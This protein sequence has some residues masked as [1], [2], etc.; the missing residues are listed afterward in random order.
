M[1]GR[2]HEEIWSRV[3]KEISQIANKKSYMTT[4]KMHTKFSGFFGYS[5]YC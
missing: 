5:D 3:Q 4:E 2:G 1:N